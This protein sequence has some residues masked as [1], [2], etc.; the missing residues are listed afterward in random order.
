[1]PPIPSE[2]K[3]TSAPSLPK[4]LKG[5][6]KGV[7]TVNSMSNEAVMAKQNKLHPEQ[8]NPK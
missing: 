5:K 4:P 1:M 3:P 7:Q 2:L 6:G 8:G